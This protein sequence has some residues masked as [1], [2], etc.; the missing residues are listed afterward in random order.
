MLPSSSLLACWRLH[1]FPMAHRVPCCWKQRVAPCRLFQPILHA[2][3]SD[4]LPFAS[5]RAPTCSELP[6]QLFLLHFRRLKSAFCHPHRKTKMA[7]TA[8]VAFSCLRHLRCEVWWWLPI[9]SEKLLARDRH[10][11][12]HR[13]WVV[14]FKL[15][16]SKTL[17]RKRKSPYLSL[18]LFCILGPVYGM[19]APCVL[20]CPT[21]L[22][23]NRHREWSFITD[24]QILWNM[25]QVYGMGPYNQ[26]NYDT[27][28]NPAI[29]LVIF[30]IPR[31]RI[32]FFGGNFK[33]NIRLYFCFL[34]NGLC[35]LRIN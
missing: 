1:W 20:C 28:L 32:C 16:E 13:L 19:I 27:A 5:S 11:D 26:T 2:F 21:T 3:F 6:N 25:I 23:A 12:T 24:I 14:C 34:C 9:V 35:A 8:E 30:L 17:K 18:Q 22:H 4:C 33:K 31:I 29:K 15:F 10:K 7:G